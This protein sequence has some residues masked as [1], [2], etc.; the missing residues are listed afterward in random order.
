MHINYR[1][2]ARIR[3]GFMRVNT[4]I[5]GIPYVR[6]ILIKCVYGRYSYVN[7]TDASLLIRMFNIA[8]KNKAVNE[9][10]NMFRI[11]KS[12]STVSFHKCDD[13]Q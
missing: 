10:K 9:K 3:S 5:F 2:S 4:V 7:E 1:Q 13:G 12:Y 6:I 8:R 11:R